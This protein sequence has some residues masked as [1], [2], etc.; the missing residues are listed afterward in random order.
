MWNRFSSFI[1]SGAAAKP[2]LKL[3]RWHAIRMLR[4]T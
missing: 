3:L 2:P 1:S 4:L